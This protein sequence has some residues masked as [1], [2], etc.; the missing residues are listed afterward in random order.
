MVT[1]ENALLYTYALYLVG[2]L[3]SPVANSEKRSA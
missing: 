2:L 3:D 1:S